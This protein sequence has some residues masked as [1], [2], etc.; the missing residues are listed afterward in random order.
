MSREESASEWS[1]ERCIGGKEGVGVLCSVALKPCCMKQELANVWILGQTL[2]NSLAFTTFGEWI[3]FP[4]CFFLYE[5]C[6]LFSLR[7]GCLLK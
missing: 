2:R 7:S 4:S 5:N 3:E 6:I 1:H